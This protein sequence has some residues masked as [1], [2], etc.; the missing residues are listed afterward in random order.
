MAF[1]RAPIDAD[2]KKRYEFFRTFDGGGRVG[3]AAE[4]ALALARAERIA[5][6]RG[7]VAEWDYDPNPDYGDVDPGDVSEILDCVLKDA[8]GEV[9]AAVGGNMFGHD[10]RENRHYRRFVEAQ[11]AVEAADDQDLL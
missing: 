1:M 6:E 3:H 11:L 7:W 4:D 8:Q 10:T 5:E 2:L 9:L